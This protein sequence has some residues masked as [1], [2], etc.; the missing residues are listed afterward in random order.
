MKS[1]LLLILFTL[2][3]S[4][5]IKRFYSYTNSKLNLK[6]RIGPIIDSSGQVL[7]DDRSKAELFQKFFMSVYNNDHEINTNIR[8]PIMHNSDFIDYVE[9]TS[10]NINKQLKSLPASISVS[11]DEIPYIFLK[12]TAVAT[13]VAK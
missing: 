11:P 13:N 1:Q 7:T 6:E 12:N 8:S 10:S 4:K 5:N 2:S 3:R 9:I